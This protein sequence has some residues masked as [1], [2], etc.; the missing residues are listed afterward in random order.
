[1]DN[2]KIL[3]KKLAAFIKKFYLNELLK[4]LILFIAIGLLYF[5]LTLFIE[6]LLWLAPKWRR[7]LFWTFILVEAF[8]FARFIIFPL[9]KLFRISKGINYNEA[10]RIIGDHFPEVSDKLLN[11]LQLKNNSRQTDLLLAGIDQKSKELRPVPFSMAIDFKKNL[12]YLKYAAI[13]VVILGLLFISGQEEI[14]SSS[15]ERVVHYKTAYEPPAPFSFELK[16]DNLKVRENES[17]KLLVMTRGELIPENVSIKYSGQTY[18]LNEVSPGVFRYTFENISEPF[19]FSLFGNKVFSKPYFVEVIN[20]P[21]IRNLQMYLNFPKHTGLNNEV[22][23]GTGNSIVPEGTQIEW[24]LVTASTERVNMNLN[25]SLIDFEREG[26]NYS[27]GMTVDRT[28]DYQISTSN[29]EIERFENLS[30]QLKVVKDEFPRILLEHKKDSLEEELHYFYG[31]VSDD[32]GIS[33]VNLVVYPVNDPKNP[34]IKAIKVGKGPVGEFLN[35][36]PD[37]LVLKRGLEYEFYF[38]VTDNDVINGYKGTKSEIFHYRSKTFEEEREN[39]LEQQNESIKGLDESIKEMELSEKELENLSRLQKERSELNFNDRKRLENFLRRQKQQNKIMES[40]TE[41]LKKS[42]QEEENS[43]NEDLKKDLENRL[44]KREEELKEN[45]EILKEL[46]KYSEKIQEE[47]LSE[48]LEELS[49][50]AKTRERNLEQLLELTK[51]YYVQEKLRKISEDLEKLSKQQEHLSEQNDETNEAQDSLSNATKETL[52]ELKELDNENKTLKKPV[53]LG[54]DLDIEKQIPQDQKRASEDIKEGKK[55]DANKQQKKATDKMKELSQKMKNQMQ[56][57]G[58]E[59]MREDVEMLRQ[60]LDNLLTFSFEQENLMEVFRKMGQNSPSFSSGIKR[61]NVLK[62]NFEHI[63]DSLFALALRNP[64]ITET[65][66]SKLTDIDYNLNKSLERLSQSEIRGGVGS[67]QY[68][69]TGAN[70]LTYLLSS[71]LGNMEQMMN[72]A[73]G[74]GKGGDGK[75][76]QLPDIIQK[77]GELNEKMKQGIEKGGKE[78]SGKDGKKGENG[79]SEENSEELF[80]IFQEQQLLRKALEEKLGQKGK[81]GSGNT[82]KEMEQIEKQLLEKGFDRET[83]ERMIRLEHN[84][85][86]LDDAELQQ[87][88]KPERESTTGKEQF[89]NTTNGRILR[90]KEYFNTTEILNRQSLPLRQIYRQKVKQY[91]ERGDH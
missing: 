3:T 89:E 90:A 53:D 65:I 51:K 70:D 1:M 10:S 56:M 52:E 61:Q 16:N 66:N 18:F 4:G 45:E 84:L 5:L 73:M 46:E 17:L 29:R 77:Q 54:R 36:F 67:Q 19:Q 13:P 81:S 26:D 25:D 24:S 43:Y 27:L 42:L 7:I 48:K 23:E 28:L 38:E 58:M 78:G 72:Q 87:G 44:E 6:H 55:E 31:K 86:D 62:E 34:I 33:R 22:I 9:L 57:G 68:V 60:I 79:N 47:G 41:K 15:Y 59:Q 69:I 49:K 40:Y 91:F 82:Q 35:V 14:I 21:R 85:L 12:P 50:G 11:V 8:F 75:G 80:K 74:K 30:Y 83:Y 39:R 76:M 88:K 71:V 32:Y 37:N 64:M 20:V 2:F 63:D